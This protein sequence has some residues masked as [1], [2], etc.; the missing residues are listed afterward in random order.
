M[1]KIRK[2]VALALATVMMMAMSITAFADETTK[3]IQ[4]KNLN[5]GEGTVFYAQ[6][7]VEDRTTTSG[8]AF[9]SDDIAASFLKSVKE[10]DAQTALA[11][12]ADNKISESTVGDALKKLKEDELLTWTQ[13]TSDTSFTVS[14]PGYYAVDIEAKTPADGVQKYSY[15]LAG[16]SVLPSDFESSDAIQMVAKKAPEK[17]VKTVS[18]TTYVETEQ[19]LTYTIKADVPYA[20]EG[21][22][23]KT[24][25]I[26]DKLS[27]AEMQNVNADKTK[28]TVKVDGVDKE[29]DFSIDN[30]GRQ[31]FVLDLTELVTTP[32]Q[33]FV[34]TTVTITYT[35]VVKD[36][37]VNNISYP[38]YGENDPEDKAEYD[39]IKSYSGIVTLIKKDKDETT[40]SGAKFVLLNADQ[41][42]V[43]KVNPQTGVIVAWDDYSEDA[44][45]EAYYL[46]TSNEGTIEVK[47]L[48]RD[49]EYVFVEKVAPEGYT[50]DPTP[51]KVTADN[52]SSTVAANAVQEATITVLDTAL[53]RLP[54]TG[55]MGTTIFTVLGVA[56][57]AMASAL[58]F[59]TK[60]KATK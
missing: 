8:W 10:T 60:K 53:I 23:V 6:V 9:A 11:K 16:V 28:V 24:F 50:V 51:Q 54:F 39:E 27:G 40:L 33:N 19:V 57:M 17:L 59:A 46:E 44:N 1:K 36:T 12:F 5:A 37:T 48:D 49:L 21:Q 7:I 4:I 47:G 35:A 29:A 42:K 25:K 56:I 58:Y 43:A 31:V 2:I 22:E 52:W 38:G 20:Y 41:T 26:Y 14:K 18:D 34:P 45:T 13:S 15:S 3:T 55:G 32:G 30:K